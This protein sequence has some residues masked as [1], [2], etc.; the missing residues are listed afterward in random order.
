MKNKL[1]LALSAFALVFSQTISAQTWVEKMQDPNV[2]FYEVQKA[3]NAYF[4][5]DKQ[6][7]LQREKKHEM[8]E[9][10][11]K[12]ERAE[13]NARK[14]KID[15]VGPREKEEKTEV[16][17]FEV[18]K[19]WEDYM[20]PRL[21]PS[22][23]RQVMIDAMNAYLD[24]V[25]A[26]SGPMRAPGAGSAPTP[27]AANWSIIGPTTTIPAGGGA[28]RCNFVRFDPLTTSTI[29][30]GSPGGGFWKS[31]NSGT[32]W[33]TT[34]DQLPIIGC[35]DLAINPSNGNI[36]YLATGD[37]EAQDT[38]S[39]GVYKSTDQGATWAI[40]GLSWAVTN[41][42][43]ISRLL[44]NPVNPNTIHAATSNGVY[45]TLNAGTTWT[46]IASTAGLNCKDIEYRPS[47]TTIV[48][49]T[50][51]TRFYKSTNGGTSYTNIT[52]GL[53]ASTAVSR[54]AIGV[55][56][57]NN[58]Y[59]YVLA[60]NTAYGYQGLY[61]STDNGTTFTT[62]STTPNL[63]GFS[64][65]GGDTGGQGW[66]TLSIAVAPTNADHV[67]VGGVNV[68]R[69]TNGGT[70]WTINAHW[71]GTGAPYVH[72][73]IHALE[74]IPGSAT[75]YYAGCDG[76][77]FRTAAS[78]TSWTDLSNGLQI[79]QAYRLGCATTSTSILVTGLQDNG[80]IRN[81][82]TT[83]WNYIQGGDGMEALV[84]FTNSNVQYG[85]LY[86]G[87]V[88]RTTTGGNLTTNIVASGGTGVN[89][90]GDWVTPY[91]INPQRATTLVI[92][93]A[94]AYRSRNRGTTWAALGTVTGGTGNINAL[95]YA[96][97]DS[98]YLYMSKLDKF[99][100][101]TNSGT[102]FTDRTAG[103]PVA[104]A[105]ISY[106]AVAS[107][108]PQHVWVT[109]S[110]YSAA[111]KVWYSANAGAT[112]T[113]YST[114]LPNIPANCIVYQNG[115]TTDALY[116][117]TDVGVYYRDNTAGSWTAY[118]TGLP[119]VVVKELEIQYTAAKLRAATFGRGIWQSDLYS[120]GTALPVADFAASRTNICTGD[121]ISFTDLSTGSPTSWSW[122][123]TGGTP[124]SSTLQ[125]PASV[126]Y[127]TP[128]TY[129]VT[130]VATNI[131][132]SN[133]MT[134]TAYI[135]VTGTTALPLVEGFQGTYVPAGWY[136]NNPDADAYTW[137]QSSA[138][139]GFATS[140]MSA[141]IDNYSPATTTGGNIDELNTPKYNFS[142][143]A[144]ATMTFD[145][146]YARYNATYQDSLRVLVSTNCGATWT[147]VY[148]K[149]GFTGLQTA[150]DN[151][152]SAFIPTAAQW[153][154]ETVSLTPYAGQANVMVK[155]VARSGWGQWLY[156]DNVNI[157]GTA[158]GSPPVASF[159]GSPTTIC[160]GQ[161]VAFTDLSTNS[162]TSWAWTFTGGTPSSST[163]QNPTVT[164]NTPGS[165]SVTLTATNA[166]GSSAPV[167]MTNYI[168]VNAVPT[169][170]VNSPTIC[171]GSSA[172]LT[173]SGG[174]TYSWSTGASTNPI[175]VSPVATTSYTVSGTT[176]GC[177]GTAVST[178]TVR[179]I[180]SVNAES[181][182][183]V[184][185]G[186]SV[187]AN[188]FTST[189]TGATFTW[190]NSNTA[191]GL[192]ASGTTSVPA[193]TA[194]NA[195]GSPITATITVT[196]TLTGCAGPPLTY[197]ITVNPLPVVT[198]N[199]STICT[200]GTATL[201]AAGGTTYAWSTGAST[202]PVTVTPATTTTYTVTGTTSGC[203]ATAVSTVTV[204]GSLTI[205]V[206]SAT[207]CNGSSAVLTA[208]GGT[209]YSWS[210]GAS[211]NPLTVTPTSTT[212]Y[213]VT[214][215]TSGCS[216]TAVST[217]TVNPT[218]VVAAESNVT[219]CAGATV[220]ANTFTSTPA[221]AAF[222]WTNSN[223]AIG[224]AA[225]GTTSVP[226]FTATNATG[227]PV[228]ATI[229]VTPTL[230][231]CS[232]TPLTYTITVNPIPV[233]TV[234]SLTIC[235]G[236][237]ATLTA[238][239]GTTYSW[240]TGA[241][242]NPITVTPATTTS[243]TVT[244]TTSGCTA[245]AVS[246][247]TV[248]PSLTIT[249]NSATICNGSSA[250][251]TASGG[252]TYSWSTG[253]ATNPLTVSPATTTSYTVTGTTS[254]C[255]GT[256]TS[257]VTVNPTPAVNA[258]S[259]V[260]VC[261]G[262]TVAAN[263]FTSTPA[264]AT[265]SWTNSN[266]SI[267]L[268]ASGTTSVPAFT[269]TNASG[270]PITAVIMVTPTLSG[271]TGS[272][273]TY[274]ITVNPVP[275]VT[276]NSSTICSGGSAT[277]TAAGGTT[278]SWSTGASTNPITVSPT[279][280]TSYT[281]TGTS[282]GCTATAVS[283]VTIGT[284]I[285]VT[286]NSPSICTGS[287]A[288]LTAT[289]GTSYSWSTGASTN[290]LTVNPTSTTSYTVTATSSGCS[291]TAVS[292]VTVNPNPAI[293]VNSQ[294]ICN[295]S[296]ATLTAS[297]G[298]TYVWSTGAT[299]NPITPSP[300]ATTNYTVTGTT[301]GCSG[302][303]VSTVTVN[304]SPTVNAEANVTRCAGTT[305]PLNNFNS[306]PGGSTFNW[307][308]SNPSIGLAAS[309]TG[310]TPAFT[311]IN[312]GPGAIVATISVTATRLGCTGPPTTYT[313]TINP[314]P[315]VTV[316]SPTI[317]TGSTATLTA[318]GA[319]T[320]SWSTGSSANPISV[321]PASTT[322]YTVTGTA[323]GCT[324]T[325][326]ATVTVTSTI[327]VAVNSATV[328]TGSAAVL[329]ATG[330][331]S[332]AWSTGA[333]TNPLTVNPASTTSYTVTGTSGGCSGTAVATVTV[334]TPP[335][336]TV[337]SP[338][339]CT[340]GTAT[341]TA[342]GGTTYSWSTG[343]SANPESVN[344]TTTTSYTVTG[345][346]A[347]CSGTAVSTVTLS[348][349]VTPA[350]SIAIVSG[351]NPACA[352]DVI[353]FMATTTNAG[354][355][356]TFQWQING[357]NAGTGLSTFT[358]ATLNNGD[359]VTCNMTSSAPCASPALVTSNSITMVVNPVP[360]TPVI[361]QTGTLLSSDAPTGNQWYLD[362]VLIPG[363]TGQTYT[364]TANGDYTVVVTLAGCSSAVS[365]TITVTTTGINLDVDPYQLTVSP[366]PNDGHF[367]VT[368][369]ATLA[370]DYKIELINALGQLIFKD[371]LK[372]FRGEYKKDLSVVDY[373][374]GIYTI[375][376][377][378]EKNETVKKIV[379]Y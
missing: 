356:P 11:E 41:G 191:I 155:F 175:T 274:T 232:G 377:T 326:I 278:Y 323:T 179:P 240:S 96:P 44:I 200:G 78:G 313:I 107:N 306:T 286:V 20:L 354:S 319:T 104:S 244:G 321:T 210:T 231:G 163:I 33:T 81:A 198:V 358:S 295:G 264:G 248:V 250:V 35:T 84:D 147:Q 182:V 141:A 72:A 132:G 185:A 187:A 334:N 183:T 263:T 192:A 215:T 362:G 167:T 375:S 289:G 119:N 29:Y 243:Y 292:T 114:G 70:S 101:S 374:K 180:P 311:A 223:T 9:R 79:T 249:V 298:T 300:A 355:S 267:G 206:N 143:I 282:A 314:L 369:N 307:T 65:T 92:G 8:R 301:A 302:T 342:A 330:G 227:S 145:V 69:S 86:Y 294:T 115:S 357:S 43:S 234:N 169:V 276:V 32:T 117:G 113:A 152:T 60:A 97:S 34:T 3:F 371:E 12:A 38:Y 216:G 202:N 220:A 15:K 252:T 337:N 91:I 199:S 376:I 73:D 160:A 181:N 366:N 283:T 146:A 277:L 296:S 5:K 257:T 224:L 93:K 137:V 254:G 212:S 53:P 165:Y 170:T 218:P 158:G 320:Y 39:I 359:V 341:L 281:V 125:N 349:S 255:S 201:T 19:R 222:S 6:R 27:A 308:N 228:T 339:I 136:L 379:V 82:G 373:G 353:T 186:A 128:G 52:A 166:S 324:A 90:D 288:V 348:P 112:W 364:F 126:C 279:S 346:S 77:V 71:T 66:Y 2:N 233:V 102:S 293:T 271:C 242:T 251:L 172:T 275:V 68:W 154:T 262:A 363:A 62:R 193:F 239:G 151:S 299:T 237:S 130:L 45:R 328:C 236:G 225:S 76:G 48:Y 161:T 21:F 188:T 50:T 67:L 120:P 49:M 108:N 327:P 28:G 139:G 22:G 322:S 178:V 10:A 260:T 332:Y 318:A 315:P 230:S 304:A 235:T 344:P 109:F 54:L 310:G 360:P 123:F 303:A 1:L 268:A 98:M 131:N 261:A 99:Y 312:P 25:N 140:T 150:P 238:A 142:A 203:T 370:A 361:T 47:D 272:P 229:T 94:Q 291:G 196:P 273:L 221:G 173:A 162:P 31:T 122:T 58:T 138:A 209:T 213:T 351:S 195:T 118:N 46:Q 184:C 367:S 75:T 23:D 40:T 100:A 61:R 246:T 317:C 350:I 174:T 207:I 176:S 156:L 297:G 85:E 157:T 258:E 4:G 36:M 219:A 345:T 365:N 338:T 247:V 333:S 343:S 190:T 204:S 194:T 372:G 83:T 214:G 18:Y 265:F 144:T 159:S 26:S 241:S 135:T 378:N 148:A 189:P 325:A 336:I 305:V 171:S 177:T 208:S 309:G 24:S 106:I 352:G 124:S 253:A 110:G 270:S 87:E 95:A 280:T 245:T 116:V 153:R 13:K 316:N 89:A 57:A 74:Y 103:L 259:N 197:T 256:A 64:S 14:G 121:C 111:N 88:N 105:S 347:G 42:R 335:V 211:T 284:S 164:Y 290:P 7:E 368:F 30:T 37:G 287:A 329:T 55:S 226:S 266:T 16:A 340:G 217:V 59:V 269:A 80:T 63:L 205:T 127:N 134:K 17:N 168:T 129:A 56:A 285:T 51:T 331:S 133:T 149:G